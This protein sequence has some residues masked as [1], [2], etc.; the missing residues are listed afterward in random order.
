MEPVSIIKPNFYTLLR[1]WK[2]I[3]GCGIFLVLGLFLRTVHWSSWLAIIFFGGGLVAVLL[4]LVVN[5]IHSTLSLDSEGITPGLLDF[6]YISPDSRKKILWEDID[7]I[8]ISKV[9]V[10]TN[11]PIKKSF[12]FSTKTVNQTL[13]FTYLTI[14]LKHPEKYK[15]SSSSRLYTED[16]EKSSLDLLNVSSVAESSGLGHI[17]IPSMFLPGGD[18]EKMIEVFKKYP[19]KIEI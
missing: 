5:F 6:G 15:L 1:L 7:H 18:A 4:I 13:N 14:Y 9:K 2:F 19:V 12:S 11:I 3:L 17:N 16:K 8:N 10:D